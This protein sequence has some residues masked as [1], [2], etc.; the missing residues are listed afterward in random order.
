MITFTH[1]ACAE[2][3]KLIDDAD[4]CVGVR[5]RAHKLGHHTY[6][7]Q[8]NLMKKE[9]IA[10]SDQT[11]DADGFVAYVDTDTVTYMDGA[12]VDFLSDE[13]GKGFD[14]ENPAADVKWD[15]PIAQKVQEVLD[16]QVVPGLASHGGWCELLEVKEG[17]AH[18]RLGGGCQGCAGARATLKQGI[19]TMIKNGVPEIKEVIDETDHGAGHNPFM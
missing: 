16:K 2:F 9:D 5:V 4:D 17:N 10:D 13:S 15:D 8:L 18:V 7:Y 12:T 11:I 14:I 3:K 19:E 1:T 6:R